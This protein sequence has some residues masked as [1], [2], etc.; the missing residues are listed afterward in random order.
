MDSSFSKYFCRFISKELNKELCSVK[1][2]G[3]FTS[4]QARIVGTGVYLPP[5]VVPNSYFESIVDTTDEWIVTRTGIRERRFADEATYPS[6]MGVKAAEGALERAGVA[7]ADVDLIIV[8]TMSGD[9]P[10]PS[11][12]ALIQS[13]LGANAAAMD[14]Q[15]ACTGFVYALATAKAYVEAHLARYVLVIATEKMSTLLDFRDRATCVLFGDGAAAAVVGRCGS[16]LSIGKPQLG[17]DGTG[18]SLVTVP[19]GGARHPTTAET[20]SAGLHFFQ[21]NGKELFKKA[22]R[23]AAASAHTV[24]GGA[25]L[26]SADITWFVPHQANWRMMEAIAREIKLP[27]ERVYSVIGKYG[28]TS[29]AGIGIALHELLETSPPLLVGQHLLLNGFGGGLTWGSLLLTQL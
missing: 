10:S 15:A 19:G 4:E 17:C 20:L 11:T 14:L 3:M 21:M 26:T 28:N 5:R 6:T 23:T 9:Y 12:A 24:L 1:L 25:G 16:G 13:A 29:A 18:A 27:A 2:V 8:A 7:V 22:V